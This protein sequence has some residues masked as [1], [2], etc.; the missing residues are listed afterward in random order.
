MDIDY[1]NCCITDRYT[2]S[3]PERLINHKTPGKIE[4]ILTNRSFP[5]ANYTIFMTNVLF[6]AVS[7]S[8]HS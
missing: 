7:G 3:S 1:N 2:C 5:K 4:M 6:R 8:L